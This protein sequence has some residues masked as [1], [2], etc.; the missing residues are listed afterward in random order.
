MNKYV[1]RFAKNEIPPVE[2]F[3]SITL[4]EKMGF[5]SDVFSAHVIGCGKAETSKR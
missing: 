5:R 2:A 4:Y 1:L 3:W